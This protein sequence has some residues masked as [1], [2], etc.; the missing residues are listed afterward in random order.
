MQM[1]R[2]SIQKVLEKLVDQVLVLSS[3]MK[4]VKLMD[5]VTTVNTI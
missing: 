1:T 2:W 4:L 3:K 5:V